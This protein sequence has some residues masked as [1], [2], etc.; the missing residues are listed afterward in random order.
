M[1]T[2]SGSATGATTTTR[3]CIRCNGKFE[4]T[5]SLRLEVTPYYHSNFSRIFWGLHPQVGVS[6]YNAALA[7]TPGRTDVSPPNGLPV[8]RDGRRSLERKGVTSAFTWELGVNTVEFGGWYENHEYDL[9]QGL[10][11][12]QSR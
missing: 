8:Q 9:F 1:W 12:Y 6:G 5:D 4:L 7:G 11:Q 2:T 10:A 3:A